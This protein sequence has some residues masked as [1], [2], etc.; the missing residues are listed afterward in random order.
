MDFFNTVFHVIGKNSGD[1]FMGVLNSMFKAG[2]WNPSLKSHNSPPKLRLAQIGEQAEGL[3]AIMM[4]ENVFFKVRDD[5]LY[6]VSYSDM[7]AIYW[8][9]I[10]STSVEPI[11]PEALEECMCFIFI[12]IFIFIFFFLKCVCVFS[13]KN[14]NKNKKTYFE[15]VFF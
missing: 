9:I 7:I 11:A 5:P 13:L 10:C 4:E 15:N 6:Q 3:F 1:E 14:K 8:C 12:F 2:T